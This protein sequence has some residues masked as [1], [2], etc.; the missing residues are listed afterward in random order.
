MVPANA[1][2]WVE[3]RKKKA[4]FGEAAHQGTQMIGLL[5]LS[6]TNFDDVFEIFLD[7]NK[8]LSTDAAFAGEQ[9]MKGV[10]I[11]AGLFGQGIEFLRRGR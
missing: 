7:L 5:E 9:T 8:K 1:L 3:R 10:F 11:F 2:K 4:T 6:L